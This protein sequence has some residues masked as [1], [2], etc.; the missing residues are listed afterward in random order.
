MTSPVVK[1]TPIEAKTK[2][3]EEFKTLF[4]AQGEA[5]L[6]LASMGNTTE[7]GMGFGG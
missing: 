1:R 2:S 3:N 7:H 4:A 6:Y 5:L